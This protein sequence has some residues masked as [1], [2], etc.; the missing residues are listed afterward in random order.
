MGI[1]FRGKGYVRRVRFGKR[2]VKEGEAVAVWDEYGRHREVVGPK[3][4]RLWFSTIRFLDRHIAGTG[5][6]LRISKRDGTIEHRKGPTSLF[7]NPVYH[8]SVSVL[9]ALDLPDASHFA[10]VR[11]ERAAAAA[12][13]NAAPEQDAAD[14]VSIVKGPNLYFPEPSEIVHTFTWTEKGAGALKAEGQVI[15][16]TASLRRSMAVKAQD[17]SGNIATIKVDW[18]ARLASIDSALKVAD[19]V[20]ECD[21]YVKAAIV[22]AMSVVHFAEQ[23]SA[24]LTLVRNALES[25]RL[26]S[27][28]KGSV[29][30]KAGCELLRV[31]VAD[32]HPSE[33]LASLRKQEDQ[34]SSAKMQEQLA[35]MSLEASAKRLEREQELQMKQQEHD[36][37][38]AAK[39]HE[40]E[41]AR[42]QLD[43]QGKIM[44]MKELRGLG[45]DL[46]KYLCAAASAPGNTKLGL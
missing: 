37:R 5:Q 16:T 43:T 41:T 32:V 19:P 34:L 26:M 27:G 18:R 22:E 7:E 39:K 11:K 29:L 8:V 24:L 45:V 30:A 31:D 10:V 12:G 9:S 23:G 20:A 46:T 38:L 40:A 28:L 6:Y 2:T 36:L 42:A 35:A 14:T 13:A 25:E 1:D 44:Y 17:A 15:C 3:L 4:V 21:F 33:E